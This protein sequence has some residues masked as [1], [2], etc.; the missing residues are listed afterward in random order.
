VTR[1]RFAEDACAKAAPSD[2]DEEGNKT[3]WRYDPVE[4][5]KLDA[6]YQAALKEFD[7]LTPPRE[8]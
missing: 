8:A 3:D 4:I 5:S 1:E 6:I 7:A 2:F